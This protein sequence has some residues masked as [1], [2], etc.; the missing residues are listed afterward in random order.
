MAFGRRVPILPTILIL[1]LLAFVIERLWVTDLEALERWAQDAADA[2][3]MDRREAVEALLA[4]SF[5]YGGKDRTEALDLAFEYRAK[6]KVRAVEVKL[7]KVEVQGDRAEAEAT[8]WATRQDMRGR[9]RTQLV[10]V[11]GPDG[12]LLQS[13]TEVTLY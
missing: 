6:N 2:V 5:T 4:E 7:R 12:W 1:G 8:I 11:R 13:A 9:V 3:N 10:F